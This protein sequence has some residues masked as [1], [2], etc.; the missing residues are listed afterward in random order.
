ME[1]FIVINYFPHEP[2]QVY[3]MFDT[4][5]EAL[6]YAEAQGM[7]ESGNAY[8]VKFIRDVNEE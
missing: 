6:I 1:R 2:T 8:E 5:E 4:E 3:G 7:S